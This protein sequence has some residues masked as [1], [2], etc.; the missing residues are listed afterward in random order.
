MARNYPI[1]RGV[2]T[3]P[4]RIEGLLQECFGVAPDDQDG[5]L[6]IRFGSFAR[7][8]VWLDGKI[9]VVESEP[10]PG[11]P[12]E[13]IQDTIRRFNDFLLRATGF[14]TKERRSKMSKETSKD[15]EV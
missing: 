8:T 3:D 1:K 10:A 6:T 5:R 15:S 12:K 2:S 13:S 7:L 11:T 9:L 14:T 4:K